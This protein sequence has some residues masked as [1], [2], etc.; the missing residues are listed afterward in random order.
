MEATPTS[1]MADTPKILVI[2]RRYLGDVVL[3]GSLFRN[4]RLHWPGCR[5]VAAVEPAYEGI[6]GLNPDVDLAMGLPSGALAWPAFACRLWRE[7]FTHVL[8]IDNTE[9]TALMARISGAP[10]R[11]ALHHGSHALKLP[12]LYTHLVHDPEGA[13]EAN[14]ITEYYL[15][16][17]GPAGVPVATR[18]I[19]LLP[20]EAD[21]AAWR[22]FIGAR[23]RTLLVHPGSRSPARIWPADRFAS[24]C[25]R[26]Q[27]ELDAQ[28]ILAGGPADGAM[29]DE[30]RGLMKTHVSSPG[31]VRSQPLFA[32]LAKACSA[33][34]CHDSGPMHVAAAVGI[35]VVALYGSQNPALFRPSGDGHRLV[36]PPMPCTAC[37]APGTCVPGDSYRSLCVRRN[38]VD[39]VY[40]AVRGV[41]AGTD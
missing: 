3:L 21:V 22:R 34:L 26:V 31:I 8:D 20:R 41:L 15:K 17:L 35:P 2:R 1:R 11:L 37:V 24:V 14:P 5:I 25:D 28:V 7:R 39:D 33:M 32:A 13:H 18:E 16:A 4:L 30:I 10:F 12:F 36:I 40:S 19:R 9:R 6:L 38:S 27:D 29:L 23:G